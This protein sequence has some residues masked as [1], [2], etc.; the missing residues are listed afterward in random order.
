MTAKPVVNT[1]FQALCTARYAVVLLILI[2]LVPKLLARKLLGEVRL[3]GGRK[4]Q[5]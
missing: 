4:F 3:I 2:G 5:F 1:G